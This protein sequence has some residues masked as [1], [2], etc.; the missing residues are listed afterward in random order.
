M[1]TSIEQEQAQVK[2]RTDQNRAAMP[3]EILNALEMRK[4]TLDDVLKMQRPAFED[5]YADLSKIEAL[6]D[7]AKDRF[8]NFKHQSMSHQERLVY[9]EPTDEEYDEMENDPDFEPLP[10]DFFERATPF[11]R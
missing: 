2:E 3:R 4:L 9:F 5:L 10:S 7:E 11:K 1:E 8:I 6:N